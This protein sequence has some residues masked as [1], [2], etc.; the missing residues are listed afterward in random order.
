MPFDPKMPQLERA[1][2]LG[3]VFRRVDWLI[4]A[5]ITIAFS[6]TLARVIEITDEKEGLNLIESA[7]T[8]VYNA[9][10]LATMH[11]ERYSKITHIRD[12]AKQIDEC[13]RAFFSGYRH[14]AITSMIPILEGIIRKI[15]IQSG[16][17]VGRGTQGLLR[18]FEL[19]VEEEKS[20]PQ[21]YERRLVMFELF[22]DFMKNRF[23]K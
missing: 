7:M 18:E 11:L 3:K 20:S 17:D 5:F 14:V 19:L 13:F 8:D 22:L 23:L 6:E 16:R 21:R 1:I 9:Q 12:F 4:P 2:W 10:Y 15:A